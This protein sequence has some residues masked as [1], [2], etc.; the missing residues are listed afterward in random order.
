MDVHFLGAAGS[1][2]GS[3]TLVSVEGTHLLVDCGLFQGFKAL[4]ARNWRPLPFDA[5]KLDA[6]LLTHAHIDHSGYLPRLVKEGFRGPVWCTQATADLCGLLLPDSGHLQEEDAR[7]ANKRGFSKHNPAQPLYTEQEARTAL[8][9]LAPVPWGEEVRIGPISATFLPAGHILGASMVHL[10]GP[11]GS[12]LFTGD[13]GRLRDPLMNPPAALDLAPDLLILESTYGDRAHS[14]QDP[15]DQLEA[16]VTRTIERDGVVLIPAFAIGRAQAVLLGLHRLIAQGRLPASLPIYLNSPMAVDAT[17]LYLRHAA[18]HRL[19]AAETRAMIATAKLI[20]TVQESERLNQHKGPAVILSA[21]GMLTGGRVLH[22]LKAF[23]PDPKNTLLLAGFQAAGTRGASIA[24]GAESVRIHGEEVPIACEVARI[25]A[26]SAHA[27]ANEILTWLGRAS[28]APGQIVLNHGEPQASDALRQRIERELG[29]H[30]SVAELGQ[31]VTLGRKSDAPLV[32]DPDPPSPSTSSVPAPMDRSVDS[33]GA[34][35]SLVVIGGQDLPD[36]ARAERDHTR[37]SVAL[38]ERPDDQR[39][40]RALGIAERALAHARWRQQLPLLAQRAKALGG[41]AILTLEGDG[42]PKELTAAC[43][44]IEQP[45]VPIDELALRAGELPSHC[46]AVMVFPGGLRTL[47]TLYALLES[48]HARRCPFVLI[49]RRFW[50][51]VAGIDQLVSEGMLAED[52]TP[53]LHA[54]DVEQ[55]WAMLET[56]LKRQLG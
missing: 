9:S 26:W 20:R 40:R 19:S 52:A 16:V 33:L 47:A 42:L 12:A 37:L 3:R 13:L 6:V 4:R 23:A 24:A 15:L 21:S 46:A 10:D 7:Y 54:E 34:R 43:R 29:W 50:H 27:D 39:A 31:L 53:V 36:L 17:E 22:H 45:I 1:V 2:T 5:R 8:A 49:G 48:S 32:V 18:D 25:D 38:A 28:K 11:D 56:R 30:T 55:A 51:D 35:A 14:E 41:L 44:Q